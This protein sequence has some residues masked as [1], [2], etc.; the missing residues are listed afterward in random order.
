MPKKWRDSPKM[1]RY[2]TEQIISILRQADTGK[3]VQEVCRGNNLSEQTF[4]CWGKKYGNLE[5]ADA[6]RF[7]ELE[8]EFTSLSKKG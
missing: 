2:T 1:V 8:K 4:Y 6:K 5:L 7:M 3:T